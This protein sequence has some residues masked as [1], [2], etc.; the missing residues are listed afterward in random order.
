MCFDVALVLCVDSSLFQHSNFAPPK[1][2]AVPSPNPQTHPPKPP[3]FGL[4][5]HFPK[6][7]FL[8]RSSGSKIGHTRLNCRLKFR[9]LQPL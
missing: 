1:P 6:I 4:D 8:V 5:F 9:T 2:L 3:L 7:G